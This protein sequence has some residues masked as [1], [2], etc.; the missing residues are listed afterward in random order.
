[1][2]AIEELREKE[3][4]GERLETTQIKKMEGEVEIRK[5]LVELQKEMPVAR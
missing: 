1:L 3:K 4:R 2:K 5:E